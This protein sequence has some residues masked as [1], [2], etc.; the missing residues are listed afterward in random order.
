MFNL[1]KKQY[2]LLSI[3]LF[4]CRTNVPVELMGFLNHPFPKK[5]QSFVLHDEVLAF[6][7]SYANE[8]NLRDVIKF[9]NQVVNVRPLDKDR[10]EVRIF[11]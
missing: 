11:I 10:W 1:G 6:L 4:F 9:Q 3:F 7:R 2:M 5:Q 8:Y